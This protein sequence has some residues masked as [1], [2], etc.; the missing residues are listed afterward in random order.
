LTTRYDESFFPMAFFGTMHEGG[1]ALYDQGLLPEHEGTPL[2]DAVSLGIHESQSRLW[3][4]LVGRSRPFWKHFFPVVRQTFPHVLDDVTEEEFYRG[5]N[6]VKPSFIRVEADEVHYN[7]HIMLRFE[8]ERDLF[9]G[10]LKPE[11]TPEV[12]RKRMQEYVGATPTNDSLG[13]LQD[14]H[15]AMGLMGYFPTY[16]LGNLYAAQFMSTVRREIPD[17]EGRIASGDLKSLLDWLRRKIHNPGMTLRAEELVK[18]VT[19]APL[20]ATHFVSYLERKYGEI[21]GF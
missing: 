4:N 3:E 13:V 11:E 2:G 7:L 16:A 14:I 12:W 8:I 21:Y 9:R 19:G 6:E 18:E 5:V 1:H 10:A 15:W 20:D 17:L